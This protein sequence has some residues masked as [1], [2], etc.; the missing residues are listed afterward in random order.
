MALSLNGDR[1]FGDISTGT[2]GMLSTTRPQL[3]LSDGKVDSV[4]KEV[5]IG[6][7]HWDT[8]QEPQGI[9]RILSREFDAFLDLGGGH[10]NINAVAHVRFYTGGGST[11]TTGTE[12]GK[13]DNLGN[14]LVGTTTKVGTGTFKQASTSGAQPVQSLEQADIDDSFTDYKGTSAADGTRSISSDTTEDAAKSGAFR[15]EI[16]GTTRWI[17]FYAGES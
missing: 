12:R 17:R 5:A 3:V 9:L 4:N 7:D 13:F 15:I 1:T 16:N 11:S 2:I 14:F 6:I 8:A 10:A